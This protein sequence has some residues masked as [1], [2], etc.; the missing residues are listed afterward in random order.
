MRKNKIL[1]LQP[2]EYFER[3][4]VVFQDLECEYEF[5]V[6][7]TFSTRKK[8]E[9]YSCFVSCIDHS[10]FSRFYCA[11]AKENDVP[12]LLMMDGVFEWSNA[13]KNGFL[14]KR[15]INLLSPFCY[16]HALVVDP[17]LKK[18]LT[19]QGVVCAQYLPAPEPNFEKVK[20]VGEFL[21]TTANSPYFND[22]ERRC[23]VKILKD[24]VSAL[25][26]EGYSYS[27]RIYDEFLIR[28]LGI[29]PEE[30]ITDG[31]IFSVANKFKAVITTPSTI[32]PQISTLELPV[33][34]L[35]YRD[36]PVFVQTGWRIN[37]ASNLSAVLDSMIKNEESRMKF[38]NAQIESVVT[39]SDF[40]NKIVGESYFSPAKSKDVARDL[41]NDAYVI[42]FE[43]FVRVL[44]V[45]PL[46]SLKRLKLFIKRR[47]S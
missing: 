41:K 10:H 11:L 1:F 45:G 36:G 16:S 27:Y 26:S 43:F 8:I 22:D 39:P 2:R 24:V 29:A 33:A 32:A 40:I 20:K 31:D 18:N 4:G 12:S 21:I 7:S 5:G 37:G 25:K 3:L 30:N 9:K 15:G 46:K 44:V 35:D 28:E 13:T 42:S 47:M 34:I 17:G 38:Q 14:A 19:S 23:L 6:F